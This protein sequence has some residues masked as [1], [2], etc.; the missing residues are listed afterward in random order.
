MQDYVLFTD[1]DCDIT[2]VDCA[3]YGYHLISMPYSV[4]GKTIYPYEDFEVFEADT[5]YDMLRGG[6]LPTTSALTKEKYIEYFEPIFAEG[7]DILYAHFSRAMS[8]SFGNMDKAYEELLAKYP[9]RKLYTIDTKGISI[10]SRAMCIEVGEMYLA[11]KSAEEIVAWGKEN[12]DKFACYFFVDDLRFLQRS[13]RV[14]GIAGTVGTLLGIRP[15][16]FI[17]DEGKMVSIGK[18]KGRNKAV[19]RLVQYV[20]EL[21]DHATQHRIYIASAGADDLAEMIREALVEEFGDGLD[22]EIVTVNPTNGAHCG[23]ESTGVCFRAIHR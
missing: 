12:V 17:N 19:A 3:K 7:K 23:P 20:R 1:S 6:T 10:L 22:L 13:G 16:L 15:I 11:G 4:E 18:E 5:Y 14:S 21:G 2:P 9:E 8:G